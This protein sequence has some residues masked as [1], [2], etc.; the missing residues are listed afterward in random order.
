MQTDMQQGGACPCPPMPSNASTFLCGHTQTTGTG[1]RLS[2]GARVLASCRAAPRAHQ[3]I[4]HRCCWRRC[5][6]RRWCAC[7]SSWQCPP[8]HSACSKWSAFVLQGAESSNTGGN[9]TRRGSEE[10]IGRGKGGR[11]IPPT[12]A[13]ALH[14]RSAARVV[15]LLRR[16]RAGC[17]VHARCGLAGPRGA[18]CV[19]RP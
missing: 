14:G 16:W 5:C 18:P 3:S 1:W 4:S 7:H 11:Q 6:R 8:P 2:A 9:G 15:C 10:S 12:K 17:L 19:R 13:G